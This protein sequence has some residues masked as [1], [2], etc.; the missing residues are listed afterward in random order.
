MEN[1]TPKHTFFSSFF[2]DIPVHIHT[3][4]SIDAKKYVQ[5]VYAYHKDDYI[6]KVIVVP[7]RRKD[8]ILTELEVR[9]SYLDKR[10]VVEAT[11]QCEAA[12]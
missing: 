11:K 1:Y 10:S 5:A 7:H 8:G 12:I 6:R 2:R 4:A 3:K 9:V